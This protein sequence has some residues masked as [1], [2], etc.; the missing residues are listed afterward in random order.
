VS[1]EA[2]NQLIERWVNDDAF[3]TQVRQD[4][5]AT[6]R[7]TGLE[8]TEEEWAGIRQVDWTLSDEEL[9]GRTSKLGA[10]VT[11]IATIDL[12]PH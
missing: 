7:A 1:K 6:I 8:L 9:Q 3:R 12:L 4:P 2:I 10:P 11:M 5:E